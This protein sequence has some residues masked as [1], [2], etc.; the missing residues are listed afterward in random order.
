[1]NR[2]CTRGQYGAGRH[3]T[4]WTITGWLKPTYRF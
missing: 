1:M 3:V 4:F 2:L